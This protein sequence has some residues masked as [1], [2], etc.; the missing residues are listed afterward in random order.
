MSNNQVDSVY[1]AA[2]R[3]KVTLCIG[4]YILAIDKVAATLKVGVIYA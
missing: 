1:V 4:A 2:E 3:Y